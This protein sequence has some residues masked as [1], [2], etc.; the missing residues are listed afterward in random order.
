MKTTKMHSLSKMF[1]L[2]ICKSG[3]F[4]ERIETPHNKVS[5]LA[6]GDE[7]E[8][9]K[10]TVKQGGRFIMYPLEGWEALEW[11]YILGGKLRWDGPNGPLFLRGGDYVTIRFIEEPAIFYAE[12]DVELIYVSSRPN[13]ESMSKKAKE[14]TNL[15]VSV[16]EKDGYTA[17]H[18]RRISNLAVRVGEQLK[19]TRTR[20]RVLFQGAFLHDIGKVGVPDH[21]LGKPGPLT[22]AEWQIMK[23]HPTFGRARVESTYLHEAAPIIEQHHERLDG[24]GY[25]KGLS[26]D[27]IM[28][29][30]RIVAVVDS[31]DAMTTDRP[32]RKALT[33]EAAIAEIKRGSG[34]I[35]DPAVVDAFLSVLDKEDIS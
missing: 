2:R 4:I 10:Q 17:D 26:G 19:L 14:L 25:P 29:E 1:G 34:V 31:Y 33:K 24:S 20:Q 16:E 11:L 30:S 18:C 22:D 12:T 8:I 7:T 5:L 21:I 9:C 15:A 27:D 23:R 35:Y 28:L 6:T 3:E 32:Y 13:F